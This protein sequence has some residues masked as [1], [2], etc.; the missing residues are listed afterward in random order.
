M[1]S[2]PGSL[3]VRAGEGT[4]IDGVGVIVGA[5]A[6]A[7]GERSARYFL[8]DVVPLSSQS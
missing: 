3:A 1:R 7:G 4:E 6:G 5:G 2:V 8:N